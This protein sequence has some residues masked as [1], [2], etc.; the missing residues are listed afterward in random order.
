MVRDEL[1][2]MRVSMRSNDVWLGLPYDLFQFSSLHGAVAAALGVEQGTYVHTV[3]SMHIY[4]R[5]IMRAEQFLDS[6]TGQALPPA[7][8]LWAP[9]SIDDI[10]ARARAILDGRDTTTT[11]S[12][13][14]WLKE[15]MRND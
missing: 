7:E 5:D 15:A 12:H 3:G 2:R 4:E 9:G 11:T 8:Q 14:Q 6:Y 13:E 10:S 1:L